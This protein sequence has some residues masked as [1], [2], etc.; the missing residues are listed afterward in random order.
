[1]LDTSKQA[2]LD[3]Q[4]AKQGA[5]AGIAPLGLPGDTSLLSLFDESLL[6]HRWCSRGCVLQLGQHVL[7]GAKRLYAREQDA[8]DHEP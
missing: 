2:S 4:R 1:M 3:K 6:E 5:S 8:S 7:S